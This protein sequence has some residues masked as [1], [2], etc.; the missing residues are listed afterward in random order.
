MKTK[1]FET[2]IKRIDEINTQPYQLSF[3]SKVEERLIIAHQFIID[4]P[5]DRITI[6]DI[7]AEAAVSK[8]HLIRRF[9]DLFGVTPI[10]LHLLLK[11]H[12]AKE[13]LTIKPKLKVKQV[14]AR[15]GYPDTFSFSKYFKK[16][17]G[18]SP[19]KF[20]T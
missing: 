18:I 19:G 13:M 5:F 10:Q 11:M 15:M 1:V 17:T 16:T 8:Y 20:E 2:S 12:K 14:A 3:N 6:D 7:A 4:H 9:R